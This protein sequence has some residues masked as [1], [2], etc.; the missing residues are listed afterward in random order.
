M[1]RTSLRSAAMVL[2]CV[3]SLGCLGLAR[4][5]QAQMN[6]NWEPTPAGREGDTF[7]QK[8]TVLADPAGTDG[9]WT[10][11]HQLGTTAGDVIYAGPQYVGV[12]RIHYF[13]FSAFG[14]AAASRYTNG[15]SFAQPGFRTAI[16]TTAC[17]GTPPPCYI[18]QVLSDDSDTQQWNVGEEEEYRVTLENP[19]AGIFDVK[20]YV[21]N[22]SADALRQYTGV[23]TPW[24]LAGGGHF[25]QV[26]APSALL[27]GSG[28][29]VNEN[30]G[31]NGCNPRGT[32]SI[33]QV[34][35]PKIT[36][37]D[38]SWEAVQYTLTVGGVC[39]TPSQSFRTFTPLGDSRRVVTAACGDGGTAAVLGVDNVSCWWA[40]K[41]ESCDAICG[42][43]SRV[44]RVNVVD[45]A[46]G[47]TLLAPECFA[48]ISGI[49][50]MDPGAIVSLADGSG[51][52]CYYGD[53]FAGSTVLDGWDASAARPDVSRVCSC[54]PSAP[55]QAVR[56][57]NC[58]ELLAIDAS[59]LGHS[60][61]Y[62]IWP[63]DERLGSDGLDVYC[64]MNDYVGSG[65]G[66]GNGWTLVANQAGT[67][68]WIAADLDLEPQASYGTYSASWDKTSS[69]YLDHSHIAGSRDRLYLFRTGDMSQWCA[70][71][72]AEITTANSTVDALNVTIQAGD[73]HNGPGRTNSLFRKAAN[74][75]D[76]W[77]GCEGT[78]LQND[79]G[80]LWGENGNS[81]HTSFKN[82]HQGVGLFVRE[83]C[84]D[85]DGDGY[86]AHPDPFGPHGLE[87]D[88][89]DNDASV[90]PPPNQCAGDCDGNGA[91]NV[92]ELIVAV[93]VAL[94]N[95]RVTACRAVDTDADGRVTI[96]E[97]I[98]A[99]GN[100]LN[101]CPL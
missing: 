98:T 72:A 90:P 20:F 69:Y 15:S 3:A 73:P 28:G 75:E 51:L 57:R 35:R 74:A 41:G 83:T 11:H 82:A 19:S 99:V 81:D 94:D 4:Q 29:N 25:E 27:L 6:V 68:D 86:G 80:M 10:W 13:S 79:A 38:Q 16:D 93:N 46:G 56:P 92:S 77:F 47:Q 91:V 76:P 54:Q 2:G 53:N 71:K 59:L 17:D 84:T 5:T 7:T 26:G 55:R 96:N 21:R 48:A 34:G 64:D 9:I 50:L 31:G 58:A 87:V 40:A 8:W 63:S 95:Q 67:G 14:A 101:N 52:G 89:D 97:I 65:Y 66:I 18:I 32:G 100:A 85:R 24:I 42:G 61:T 43:A 60:G 23:E 62:T 36:R 70:A 44:D 78:Y 30:P 39:T 49:T 45:A 88:P 12:H 37:G 22:L 1:V 33:V